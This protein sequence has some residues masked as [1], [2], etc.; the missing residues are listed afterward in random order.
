[1]TQKQNL[2]TAFRKQ[3]MK[4]SILLAFTILAGFA[5]M[6]QD[7]TIKK[8]EVSVTS[9]FKP[10]LKEAAKININATPPTPDS[11]RPKLQYAIP[12]QNL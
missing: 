12:N 11:T 5:G 7:T 9:T 2:E 8:R 10:S 1:M 4:S 3:H 6:A